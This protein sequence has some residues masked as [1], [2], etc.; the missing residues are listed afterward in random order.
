M[1]ATYTDLNPS[2]RVLLGPGPSSVHPRVLRAMATPLVG[3]LDPDFVEIMGEVKAL[4][5]EAFATNNQLTLAVS[6]TG[7]SAM[8]AALGNLIE[9]GDSVL[10][11]SHGYFGQRLAD[12]SARYGASVTVLERPWG[13]VFEPAEIEEALAASEHK[14]V[15]L[16]HAETSTG[17]LQPMIGEIAAACHQG[18]AILVLD[19]VTSLGGCPVRVD[20][21]EVDV[22]YS[23]GQKSLSAPPG[24]SPITVSKRARKLIEGR[25]GPAPVFYFDLLELGR[26]WGEDPGYHHTAPISTMYALRE[27][28]RLAHEEGYESRFVRHRRNAELLWQGLEEMGI[29]FLIPAERRIPQLATPCIPEGIDGV[30]I[31]RRMLEDY[32]IEIAGGFGPLGGKIWRIG[33]MGHSSRRENVKLLLAAYQELLG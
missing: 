33:L 26:Y 15:T 31:R 2:P 22:A 32:N 6:G 7:T 19:C 29:E 27:A 5:Q 1:T 30:E 25:D 13:E 28:L 10:A 8:E 18:G 23:A 11:C 20:E 3:H 12:M 24:L 16:V 21:W 4:L 9:P 14:I 17:A